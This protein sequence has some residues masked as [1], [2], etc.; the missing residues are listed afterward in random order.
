MNNKQTKKNSINKITLLI[1]LIFIL[2]LTQTI[3]SQGIENPDLPTVE[4]SLKNILNDEYLKISYPADNANFYS[5]EIIDFK[6]I[7]SVPYIQECT[8]YVDDYSNTTTITKSGTLSFSAEKLETGDYDWSI[9]CKDDQNNIFKQVRSFSV[10]ESKLLL[11]NPEDNDFFNEKSINFSYTSMIDETMTCKLYI[12]DKLKKTKSGVDKDETVNV[13]MSLSNGAHDW[14]VN[15]SSSSNS[16]S[17]SKR[18]VFINDATASLS[19]DSL[20]MTGDYLNFSGKNFA[21]GTSVTI[22]INNTAGTVDQFYVQIPTKIDGKN[23]G[24]GEFTSLR[25][26]SGKITPGTYKLIAEQKNYDKYAKTSFSVEGRDVSIKSEKSNYKHQEIAK[27]IGENFPSLTTNK[28]VI[29]NPGGSRIASIHA[30]S[31]GS[32][33][34]EYPILGN[35]KVGTYTVNISNFEFAINEQTSF[36][37]VMDEST[38]SDRDQDGIPDSQDNCMYVSNPSQ[39]DSDGDGKGDACDS[40]NNNNENTD[41]DGDLYLDNEDNCPLDYNAGQEDEDNDGIGDA[42][43]NNND[44]SYDYDGDGVKDSEDNCMYDPNPSQLDS[45]G[46]GKGDACDKTVEEKPSGSASLIIWSIIGLILVILISVL[47]F[48]WYEGKLDLN[49]IKGSEHKDNN[50]NKKDHYEVLHDFIYNQ[51]SNGY[52]D[53]IIRNSLIDKGWQQEDVDNAFGKIYSEI[54]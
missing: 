39:T 38:E 28:I 4:D 19:S 46:D 15:C 6:I 31:K 21:P 14:F 50:P 37:V 44:L 41:T 29:N 47:G 17:S 20:V 8:F 5:D 33:I 18:T 42:C 52:D 45:D 32:F 13:K 34:Y 27:I 30:D 9:S 16:Y 53:L 40:S 24:D 22:R 48:L 26:L 36:E 23:N 43:D 49:F 25:P 12:D 10:K 7:I 51:R 2:I 54:A 1:S 3:I 35:Y 11:N